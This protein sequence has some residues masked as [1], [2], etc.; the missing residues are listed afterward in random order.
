MSGIVRDVLPNV[1]QWS[2]GA[3]GCQGVVGRPS[4]IFGI[5]REA[6]L[7]VLEWSGGPRR[8]AGVVRGP[9]GSPG[10]NMTPSRMSAS[11]RDALSDVQEW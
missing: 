9:P 3:P 6:L 8:F 11:G 4:R 10:V 1:R 2:C 5:G 7:V